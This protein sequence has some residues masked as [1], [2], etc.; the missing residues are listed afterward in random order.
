MKKLIIVTMVLIILCACAQIESAE[1]EEKNIADT[2]FNDDYVLTIIVKEFDDESYKPINCYA[3][4]TYTGNSPIT[5]YHSDPLVVFG[6]EDDKYFDN[7]YTRNDL[8]LNTTFEPNEE[9]Q[10][11]F[12]KNGGW[13][14]DDPN[15]SFY[16]TFYKDK[17][18]K[19]P[20]GEYSL[21]ANLS[22]SLDQNN[23]VK[24]QK[25]LTASVIV[26]VNK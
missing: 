11:E 25:N 5:I 17:E 12:Q 26:V 21:S 24:T 15:A 4:L 19:L 14:A 20:K 9:V 22:Y 6:I 1:I 16:E 7:G 13:S 3:T 18:L 8:L 23:I 10:F 2:T